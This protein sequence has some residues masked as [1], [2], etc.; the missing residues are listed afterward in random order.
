MGITRVLTYL[1]VSLTL[2]VQVHRLE[3]L[4]CSRAYKETSHFL[5]EDGS[6][7]GCTRRRNV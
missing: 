6:H 7:T 3:G 1:L 4:G 2:Q 5:E